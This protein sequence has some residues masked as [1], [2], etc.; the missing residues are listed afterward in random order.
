[1]LWFAKKKKNPLEIYKYR[2]LKKK[3]TGTETVKPLG[4]G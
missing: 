3:L 1:M 2:S 4:K